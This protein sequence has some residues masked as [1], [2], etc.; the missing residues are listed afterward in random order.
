MGGT[1]RRLNRQEEGV[2]RGGNN[3]PE[4]SRWGKRAEGLP[5]GQPI[6][7]DL[8]WMSLVPGITFYG[9]QGGGGAD[10]VTVTG[11]PALVRGEFEA[12]VKGSRLQSESEP[13]CGSERATSEP[14]LGQPARCSRMISGE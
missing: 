4:E 7:S 8:E 5:A 3:L 1:D 11:D 6:P 10:K 2:K 14:A 9:T 13:P 12:S